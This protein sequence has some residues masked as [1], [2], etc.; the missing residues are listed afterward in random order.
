MIGVFEAYPKRHYLKTFGVADFRYEFFKGALRA[1]LKNLRIRA[2]ALQI[3]ATSCN[4]DGM[5]VG[6]YPLIP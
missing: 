1:P 6:T 4:S 2:P 5:A 3:L